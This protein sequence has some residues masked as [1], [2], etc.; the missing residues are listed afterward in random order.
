MLS[1]PGNGDSSTGGCRMLDWFLRRFGH[2]PYSNRAR[3]WQMKFRCPLQAGL[4]TT[5]APTRLP[6]HPSYK[7]ANF[8]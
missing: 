6:R 4:T 5:P 3:V 8:V 7:R 1:C 2:F